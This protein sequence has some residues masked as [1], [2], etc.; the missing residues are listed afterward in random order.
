MAANPDTTPSGPSNAPPSGT[1]SRWL[2]VTTAG[3]PSVPGGS[4]QAHRF[5]FLSVSARS[6][7]SPAA[8]RNQDRHSWSAPV[9]EYRR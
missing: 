1:E 7:R 8:A 6:P 2:P 9:H 3:C 4:H 5:P